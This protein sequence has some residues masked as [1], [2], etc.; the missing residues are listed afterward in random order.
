[1]HAGCFIGITIMMANW[2]FTTAVQEGAR[3][4]DKSEGGVLYEQ[5]SEQISA[6]G[7]KAVVVFA[8]FLF[9][10]YTTFGVL[11]TMWRDEILGIDPPTDDDGMD[12][13]INAV[14]SV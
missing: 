8:V 9:L 4:L 12:D 3:I 5:C 11:L 14:S 10:F 1:M 13:D 2:T 7:D 6:S